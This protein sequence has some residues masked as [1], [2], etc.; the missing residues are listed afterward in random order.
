MLPVL[1]TIGTFSV[2]SFG[3]FLSL[4]FLVGIFLIWRLARAVELDEERV[5]DLTL[6]TFFGG[7]LG[8][9][10]YYILENFLFF[11]ID[12]ARMFMIGKYPGLSLWGAFL[13][14]WLTLYYFANKFKMD[15][16][17]VA[18]VAAVGFL[19]GL[20]LGDFGCFL[21]GCDV[22]I[23]ASG[24]LA[25]TMIG[26][27]GKRFPI[28]LIEALLL[29]FL[30]LR[31][32]KMTVHFHPRGQV[33]SFA[34]V[35]LGIVKFLTQF[36]KPSLISAF[37]LPMV[38]LVLGLTIFYRVTTVSQRGPIRTPW[39]DLKAFLRLTMKLLTDKQTR[40]EVLEGLKKEWYNRKVNFNWQFRGISKFL[41][42]IRVRPTR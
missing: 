33:V 24:P 3:F 11:S 6:L 18:D 4:A 12:P 2:S 16:W 19:S 26:T 35:W 28:Q 13:G 36:L 41:R 39:Q 32:W 15:F 21:G 38:L 14:G 8:A 37:I 7:L 9:R 23:S 42:R 31:A 27:I 22:G 10:I 34:L 1:F 5:L 17:Q 40:H 30:F 25:V 29:G 20:V